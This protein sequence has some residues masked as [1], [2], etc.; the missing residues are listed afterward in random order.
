M[1][2]TEPDRVTSFSYK[3]HDKDSLDSI[4][5]L[6]KYGK[7]RGISFSFLVLKA[8]KNLTKEL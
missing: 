5:K 6:R 1:N 8:I 3:P 7:E 4:A 2:N